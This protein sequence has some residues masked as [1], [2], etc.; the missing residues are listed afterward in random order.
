M[1][2]VDVLEARCAAE[3]GEHAA[4]ANAG[5]RSF[6][7]EFQGPIQKVKERLQ[8]DLEAACLLLITC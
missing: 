6:T 4:Q 2:V 7:C 8:K 1:Q 3:R 5:A